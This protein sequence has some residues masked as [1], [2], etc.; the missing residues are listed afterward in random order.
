MVKLQRADAPVD[1][2]RLGG[3]EQRVLVSGTTIRFEINTARKE[4]EPLRPVLFPEIA[5]ECMKLSLGSLCRTQIPW[6]AGIDQEV[7]PTPKI[8]PRLCQRIGG[9]PPLQPV[10]TQDR[11]P[12]CLEARQHRLRQGHARQN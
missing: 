2:D 3:S 7:S 9:V 10:R 1:A 6:G 5:H 12:S 11:A 4:L 8:T